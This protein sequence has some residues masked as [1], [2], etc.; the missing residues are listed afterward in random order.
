MLVF[1]SRGQSLLPR[2]LLF[3]ALELVRVIHRGELAFIRRSPVSP[4]GRSL[5]DSIQY[6]SQPTLYDTQP[7]RQIL[8]HLRQL[9]LH[10]ARC[11]KGAVVE[12]LHGRSI[13]R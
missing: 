12:R 6:P 5:V 11:Q 13:G 2:L 3:V 4:E 7:C 1:S 10:I 8:D 9:A